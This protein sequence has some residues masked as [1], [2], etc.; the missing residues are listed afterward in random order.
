MLDM[1]VHSTYSDGSATIDEIARKA[2]ELGLKA[3]AVVDHSVEL[4]FGLTEAKAKQRQIEIDNASSLYGVKIYSGIECSIDAAGEIMLPDFDFEFVIASIHEFVYGRSYYERVL[5]C[6]EK[7]EIDVLGHP[8]SK[9][10]GFDDNIPE[11]DRKLVDMAEQLGIAIEL[12]SSHKSPTESFLELCRDRKLTYS[13]GS[14]AHNLSKVGDVGWSVEN[15]KRYM[16]R[17]K[18]FSP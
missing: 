3:V 11:M 4:Y 7:N 12:N 2:K 8:F 13:I 9:L 18:L 14:D 16:T 6:I 5:R 15:A 1:H 17:A 10:F